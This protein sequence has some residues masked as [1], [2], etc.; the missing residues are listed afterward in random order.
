MRDFK[1]RTGRHS[2]RTRRTLRYFAGSYNFG[3]AGRDGQAITLYTL[4]RIFE[5]SITELEALE[6]EK[7]KAESLTIVSKRKR[8]GVYYTPEWVVERVV[9]ETL[10]PRL[11]EMR[12]E[13]GWSLDLEGD[14][15]AIE[16]QLAKSTLRAERSIQETCTRCSSVPRSA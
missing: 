13:V 11:D 9:A 10:S 5:Q 7:D 2:P 4:G 16:K 14:E 12:A 6:A 3:A 15:E 1:A 8:D